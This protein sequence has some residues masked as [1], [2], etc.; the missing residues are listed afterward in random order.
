MTRVRAKPIEREREA[1]SEQEE[2][3]R[4]QERQQTIVSLIVVL[5]NS[6]VWDLAHLLPHSLQ[7]A[8]RLGGTHAALKS[9]TENA[10]LGRNLS[11]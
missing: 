9:H 10:L 11:R 8:L 2:H 5:L 3:Q 7:L 1:E 6:S 4:Q